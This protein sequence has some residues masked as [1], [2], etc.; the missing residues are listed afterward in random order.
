MQKFLK[1]EWTPF[2]G[3][4]L[5]SLMTAILISAHAN[6]VLTFIVSAAG[7]GN[8]GNCGGTCHR[9]TWQLYGTWC[10]R[11]VAIRYWK[12]TRIVREFLCLA[13]GLGDGGA[14]GFG[15]IDLGEQFVGDGTGVFT[16][17]SGNTAHRNFIP[18]SPRAIVMLM[19]LAI[20][21]MVMPTL[22]HSL[23]TPA[24][25]HEKSLSIAGA[26]V[27]LLVFF[28]SIPMSMRS[29]P[30]AEAAHPQELER[31]TLVADACDLGAGDCRAFRRAGF[32]LV[33]ASA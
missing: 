32:G 21:A 2:A 29:G 6:S 27:L 18:K 25:A 33:R 12:S 1:N 28:A 10:D 9:A 3:A 13:G 24:S 15:G 19:V 7:I 14:I 11:R 16:G 4:M 8:T 23:H 26:L 5:A 30:M 31:K 22:T 17:W 20:S